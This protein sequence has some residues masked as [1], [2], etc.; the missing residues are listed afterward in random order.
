MAKPEVTLETI[1]C[2]PM[3]NVLLDAFKLALKKN[4]DYAEPDDIFANFMGSKEIG[5]KP[6]VGCAIRMQD[7]FKRFIYYRIRT[8]ER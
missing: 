1:K 3:G 8:D 4:S 5:V 2:H 7:K 6:S